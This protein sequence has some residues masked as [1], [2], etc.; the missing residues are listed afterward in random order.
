[1][2][3]D[4]RVRRGPLSVL[5]QSSIETGDGLGLVMVP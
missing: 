2:G 4:Q 3:C 5:L 1:M